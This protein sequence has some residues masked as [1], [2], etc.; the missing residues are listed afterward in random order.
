MVQLNF[1]KTISALTEEEE[2]KYSPFTGTI[3]QVI[4][5]FPPGAN[6]LVEVKVY[7]GSKQIVPEK[8]GVALDNAT[9]TFM[10]E[11]PVREGDAIKVVW[12][13]HD[14]TYEHTISVIVGIVPKLVAVM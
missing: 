13:N 12:I 5:H 6:S 10:I 7:H 2:I 14:D 9:P 11:E 4:M 3:K 8:G 1:R